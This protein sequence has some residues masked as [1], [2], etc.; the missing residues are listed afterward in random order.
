MGSDD[1]KLMA[2]A[3]EGR[4]L[5]F[6]ELEGDRGLHVET[7]V[8]AAARLAGSCLLRS[9]KLDLTGI[10]PGSP[11]FSDLADQHGPQLMD[12]LGKTLAVLEVPIDETQVTGEVT[13]DHAPLMDCFETL[14]QLQ[15]PARALLARHGFDD[16]RG[17]RAFTLTTAI[18]IHETQAVVPA[19]S[20]FDIAVTGLVEGAKMAPP[21]A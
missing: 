19:Q 15:A 3:A 18:L 1:E 10:A 21:P 17:A 8:A 12:L 20:L 7:L 4:A 6:D 9:F 14:L 2:V 16:V 13:P 11:V 5:L